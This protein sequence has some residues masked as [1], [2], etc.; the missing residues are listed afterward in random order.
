MT[1]STTTPA[2]ESRTVVR[3]GT[4]RSALATVQAQLVADALTAV[5]G[6]QVELVP[7]TTYGD[8]SQQAQ[9]PLET[10]GGT[11][12][13]VTEIRRALLAGDIDLAVHSLKD[14]PTGQPDGLT[15]AAIPRREDPR[16]VLVARGQPDPR[17]AAGRAP[18]SAPGRR[19]APPSCWR[20]TSACRS[21]RSAATS[22][23]ACAR[24]PTVGT[25]RSS[26]LAPACSG[27]AGPTR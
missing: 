19:A 10:I 5:S 21:S 25:T 14:L 3:L 7:I 17:R 27:W 15:I 26:W 12:V 18:A 24:S 16:D 22:T 8:E 13:F 9:V 20:W 23:P 2:A 4:R 1:A 6:L 11:G